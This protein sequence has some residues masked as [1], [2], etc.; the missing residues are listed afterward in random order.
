[1]LQQERPEQV[2]Q[3]HQNVYQY[4]IDPSR[5]ESKAAASR[6]G[7][8]TAKQIHQTVLTT[9]ELSAKTYVCINSATT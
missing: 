7:G 3:I 5:A 8:W 9:F 4:Y 2:R 6:R 1:M